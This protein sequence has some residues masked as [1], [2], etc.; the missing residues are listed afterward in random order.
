MNLKRML[1]LLF[2]LSAIV[3]CITIV[4]NNFQKPNTGE[5][6]VEP[7]FTQDCFPRSLQQSGVSKKCF[8]NANFGKNIYCSE[9]EL[10]K[11]KEYY[12]RGQENDP[13]ND[14]SGKFCA[15]EL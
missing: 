13:L 3:L 15:D 1:F 10:E 14:G 4:V 12:K 6:I 8:E 2:I 9:S 7:V 5:D 11:I